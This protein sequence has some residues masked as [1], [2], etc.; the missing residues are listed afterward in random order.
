M[1]WAGVR[2]AQGL[3]CARKWRAVLFC[4]L[5]S[6][7]S[8]AAQGEEAYQI[9]AAFI[10]NFTKFVTWPE[11]LERQ[12]GDLVLCL[13]DTN[14]FGEYI[15]NL[16]GRKVRNFSLRVSVPL[17]LSEL[18]QCHIVFLSGEKSGKTVLDRL[19]QQPVL[20]IADYAGFAETGGGI[21]LMSED[22]RIRF[23]VNLKNIKGRSLDISSKLL[24]LARKVY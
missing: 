9:K 8:A 13:Y 12:G 14:P 4:I 5:I 3:S 20:T 7:L 18:D 24:H 21:E 2:A 11:V 16:N 6:F 1:D 22:N 15:F 19:A 10:L 23:D 17:N